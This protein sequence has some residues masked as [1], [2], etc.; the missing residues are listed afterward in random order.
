VMEAGRLVQVGT[1]RDIYENPATT[2]VATRLGHPAV[3]LIPR[4]LF[5][6][7]PAP[8]LTVLIGA[9]TE[10]LRLSKAIGYA[11]ARSLVGS[12]SWIEHLGD[13]NHLHLK[14]GDMELVTLADPESGLSVGDS[15][16][17]EL[18]RPL[19][20]DDAGQRISA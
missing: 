4:G 1:P 11:S 16:S 14:V 15:I 12:L 17:V 9:R 19:F 2:H 6:D 8:P 5:P 7:V 20:F 13:Q 3:N 10:H 18:A